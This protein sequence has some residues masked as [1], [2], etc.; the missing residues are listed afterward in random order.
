MVR[1]VRETSLGNIIYAPLKIDGKDKQ[2]VSYYGV[3]DQRLAEEGRLVKVWP[4][5]QLTHVPFQP[6]P[7]PLDASYPV[8]F[9]ALDLGK[10][11]NSMAVGLS[12]VVS[13]LPGL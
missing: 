3:I 5:T 10:C 12:V 2:L 13:F 11:G 6:H 7:T 8:H 1:L 9:D 4:W